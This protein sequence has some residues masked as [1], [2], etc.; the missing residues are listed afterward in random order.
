MAAVVLDVTVDGLL[1]SQH[2]AVDPL[3]PEEAVKSMV[4]YLDQRQPGARA[5]LYVDCET[6]G[7]LNVH[8]TPRDLYNMVEAVLVVSVLA[9]AFTLR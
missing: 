7:S 3:S 1:K 4:L 6:Q 8:H 9:F 2:W 5:R